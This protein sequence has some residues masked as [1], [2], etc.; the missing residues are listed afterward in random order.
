[1]CHNGVLLLHVVWAVD[2]S[3]AGQN[4]PDVYGS[5]LC[6]GLHTRDH[7]EQYC[8]PVCLLHNMVGCFCPQVHWV[9]VT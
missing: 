3:A 8:A 1:M 4:L 2:A 9:L 5:V 7:T 6:A